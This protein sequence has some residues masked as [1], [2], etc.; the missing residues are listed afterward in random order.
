MLLVEKYRPKDFKDAKLNKSTLKNIKNIS[1]IET[2]HN[3]FIYGGQGSGKYTT[4]LM[5]LQQMYGNDIYNK[6]QKRFDFS[7][8]NSYKSLEIT[9]SKYHYEIYFNDNYDYDYNIIIEFLKDISKTANIINNSFKVILLRNIQFLNKTMYE[10]IKNICEKYYNNCRFIFISSSLSNVPKIMFGFCF[11]VR[12]SLYDQKQQ[13]KDVI[14]N[15][16]VKEKITMNTGK[17]DKLIKKYKYN[18]NMIFS[19]LQ[20]IKQNKNYNMIDPIEMRYKKIITLI[21]KN[22]ITKVNDIRKEL[23]ELTSCN[24]NKNELILYLFEYFMEITSNKEEL[25]SFTNS[26]LTKM[27]KSYRDLFH[28]EYYVMTL[29]NHTT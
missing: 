25:T 19:N 20:L 28:L 5:I 13:L 18:L 4:A 26:I 10:V 8:G 22:D 23:Y 9:C 15:I 27:R 21:K 14:S 17:L 12:I 6:S 2:F 3:V 11:F 1:S 29:L 24:I 7:K 16:C